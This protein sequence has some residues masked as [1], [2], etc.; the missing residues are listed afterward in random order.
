MAIEIQ[1]YKSGDYPRLDKSPIEITLVNVDLNEVSGGWSLRGLLNKNF[2]SSKGEK[3]ND[4]A[5]TTTIFYNIPSVDSLREGLAALKAANFE[6][7]P[8]SQIVINKAQGVVESI[9][10]AP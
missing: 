9:D 5:G 8:H 3:P 1:V 4:E 7:T 2:P 6:I 10:R